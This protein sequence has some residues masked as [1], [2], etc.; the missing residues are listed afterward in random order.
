MLLHHLD[1][2]RLVI[3]LDLFAAGDE[4]EP[5]YRLVVLAHIIEALGRAGVIVEGDAGRDAVDE[6]RALVFDRRLDQRNEL[7]LVAGEAARDEAGAELQRQCGKIDRAVAID[8]AALALG[9]TVGGSGELAFGQP[10]NA[11]IFHDIDH[12]DAAA[13][14][15]GELAE[16]D[17]GAVAVARDAE[18]DQLP[19]GEVGAGQHRGHAPV[20]RIEAV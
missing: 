18:I 4:V 1:R 12:V 5:V 11:V 16:P 10:V 8:Q 7:R 2:A 13:D 19:I 20:H 17:G 9:T 14:A 3:H 15:M 6:G